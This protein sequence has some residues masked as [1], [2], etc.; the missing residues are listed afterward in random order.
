MSSDTGRFWVCPECRKHVPSRQDACRCGF[1]RTK[2]PIQIRDVPAR[3]EPRA[4]AERSFFG[5]AWSLLVIGALVGWIAYDRLGRPQPPHAPSK[6]P[7]EVPTPAPEAAAAQPAQPPPFIVIERREVPAAPV[8][9]PRPVSQSQ[10]PP[11]FV[12][13]E[14]RPPA[15]AAPV[16][17]APQDPMKSEPYWKRRMFES[18]ERVRN[19]YDQCMNQFAL[20]GV[21]DVGATNYAGVRG[22]LVSALVAQ[23]QLEEDARKEGVPPGWVRFDYSGYPKVWLDAAPGVHVDTIPHPCSVPHILAS[24][25]Q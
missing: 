2:V 14:V 7:L 10:T 15:A 8:P 11:E 5:G 18:R 3:E 20:G 1:D 21:G 16:D 22:S 23:G 6:P 4:A 19:A 13:V 9:D 24:M 12:R 17:N 25:G